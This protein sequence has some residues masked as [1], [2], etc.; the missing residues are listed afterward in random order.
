MIS[1]PPSDDGHGIGGSSLERGCEQTLDGI[2]NSETWCKK[3]QGECYVVQIVYLEM[4][5]TTMGRLGI[6]E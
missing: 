2:E 4:M 1:F 5:E 6:K 3:N